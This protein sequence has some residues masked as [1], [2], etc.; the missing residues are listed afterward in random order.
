MSGDGAG[1]RRPEALNGQG[2]ARNGVYEVLGERG[3][4]RRNGEGVEEGASAVSAVADGG[5][6]SV[7]G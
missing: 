5:G 4:A 6:A 1:M 3:A 2:I 7:A